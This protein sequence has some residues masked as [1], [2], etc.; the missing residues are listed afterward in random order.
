MVLVLGCTGMLG[1][2]LLDLPDVIGTC[3]DYDGSNS[4]IYTN[5]SAYDLGKIEYIISHRNPTYVINCIGAIKQKPYTPEQFIYLNSYFPYLLDDICSRYN[6]KLIHISTDCVFDGKN[7]RPYKEEDNTNATDIYG[8]SKALAE[9]LPH[10]LILRTS[11]IGRENETSFGMLEWLLSQKGQNIWGY[12]NVMYSGLTTLALSKIIANLIK[13]QSKIT[14]LYNIASTQINKY[15]LIDKINTIHKLGCKITPV[16]E[17]KIYRVL[18]G[19]KFNKLGY[20]IPSWDEMIGEL[21]VQ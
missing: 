20:K 2:Q 6:A 8:K 21:N 18:D 19:S 14:G 5:V 4:N 3:R 9:Y 12:A 10:A 15:L 11:I 16:Y 13:D 7:N 1:S 17:P